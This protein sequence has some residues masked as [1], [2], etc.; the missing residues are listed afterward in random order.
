MMGAS[1]PLIYFWKFR[2]EIKSHSLQPTFKIFPMLSGFTEYATPST[3]GG[4]DLE[5]F[6]FPTATGAD[7]NQ[8]LQ[9]NAVDRCNSRLSAV[10]ACGDGLAWFSGWKQ[11]DKVLCSY[12]Q[13]ILFQMS[14]EKMSALVV[15]GKCCLLTSYIWGNVICSHHMWGNLF[16]SHRRKLH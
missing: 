15:W 13:R 3:P 14:R 1:W 6:T 5:T 7:D 9:L 12:L 11:E 16:S 2:L 4:R 10:S 8:F